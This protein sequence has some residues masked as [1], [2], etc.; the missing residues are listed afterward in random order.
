MHQVDADLHEPVEQ[1]LGVL[2][3]LG[4]ALDELQDALPLLLARSLEHRPERRRVNRQ[5][6]VHHL[7]ELI[8]V[9]HD[10]QDPR[11][12]HVRHLSVH[13]LHVCDRPRRPSLLL[14]LLALF[15]RGVAPRLRAAAPRRLRHASRLRLPPRFRAFPVRRSSVGLRGGWRGTWRER[16][17]L[18]VG[19]GAL[20]QRLGRLGR[21]DGPA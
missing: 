9:E 18:D 3:A 20:E 8:L 1:P 7:A 6:A 11:Q 12:M 13:Q 14:G 16:R 15:L 19:G 4:A 21:A 10:V 17:A 5:A 2:D